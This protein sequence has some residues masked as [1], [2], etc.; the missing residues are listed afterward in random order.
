[1]DNS[2]PQTTAQ[3]AADATATTA[4]SVARIIGKVIVTLLLIGIT[5][6]LLFTCIFAYYVK[7]SLSDDLDI[8]LDDMAL[9]LASTIYYTDDAGENHELA[10]VYDEENRVWVDYENIPKYMTYAAVAIEDKRFYEHNGVDWYR[11][12]GA[13]MNM[14]IAMK[15]DFGGST[16]TQQLIKNITKEDD[17]TVQRK[18]REIFSA[19]EFE[20]NYSKDEIMEWYLNVIYLGQ[21]CNGVGTAAQ[22]Y[23]GKD[24]SELTLAECAS[25]IAITNNPSKYDPYIS[26][27]NN[28]ER[29]ELIL[30]EM[31]DQGYITYDEYQTAKAQELVLKR[32]ETED[33]NV[34]INSYY[35]E[36][37]IDDVVNDLAEAKGIDYATALSLVQRGGYQIYSCLDPDIQAIMD[38]V[39]EDPTNFPTTVSSK[40]ETIQSAAVLLDPYTGEIKALVGGVGEVAAQIAAGEPGQVELDGESQVGTDAL[41]P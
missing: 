27:D 41:Q 12:I 3:K 36:T 38:S 32:T 39:Y 9:N 37:V 8:S 19:L 28:K 13:F 1:M 22:V 23:Y 30:S 10:T 24:V 4:G 31:Y 33:T 17:I 5:T 18:L 21:R 26:K 20:R 35:V 14:F 25:I 29:Q 16:I 34:S 40:G 11:T 2:N 6:G 15:N 7:T